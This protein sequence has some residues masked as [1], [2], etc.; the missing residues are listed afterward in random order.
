MGWGAIA[1]A[2]VRKR[3]FIGCCRRRSPK[4]PLIRGCAAPSPVAR[5]KGPACVFTRMQPCILASQPAFPS[6]RASGEKVV[7]APDEGPW[8]VGCDR[9]CRGARAAIHQPAGEAE[10]RPH[11]RLPPHLPPRCHGRRDQHA[12]SPECS[13]AFPRRR[14]PSLRPRQRG[15]DRHALYPECGLAF[16]RQRPPSFAPRGGDAGGTRTSRAQLTL[17]FRPWNGA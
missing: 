13:L 9:R 10:K 3:C 7:P 6:P 17:R 2:A 1:A 12:F 14:Q 4:A 8:E 16:L 11:P 15:K 5:E